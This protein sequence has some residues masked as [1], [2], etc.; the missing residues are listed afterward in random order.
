MLPRIVDDTQR[1]S[2]HFNKPS[3]ETDGIMCLQVKARPHEQ[4]SVVSTLHH[5][6]I[7]SSASLHAARIGRTSAQMTPA[8]TLTNGTAAAVTKITACAPTA[9]ATGPASPHHF[10]GGT[11]ELE[12]E[13]EKVRIQP[14]LVRGIFIRC[15]ARSQDAAATVNTLGSR[16][17]VL[18][19]KGD[20]YISKNQVAERQEAYETSVHQFFEPPTKSFAQCVGLCL[21]TRRNADDCMQRRKQALL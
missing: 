18:Q 1:L 17:G 16:T 9:T 20:P 8:S 10:S 14:V 15:G 21:G 19:D 13:S 12:N 7:G 6:R 4:T 3:N 5:P 11:R 2:Q